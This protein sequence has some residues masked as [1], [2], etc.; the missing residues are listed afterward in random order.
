MVDR[1]QAHDAAALLAGSGLWQA[2]KT[3]SAMSD[4]LVLMQGASKTDCSAASCRCPSLIK[5]RAKH[6]HDAG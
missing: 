6:L 5:L 3:G 2:A 4:L 1:H